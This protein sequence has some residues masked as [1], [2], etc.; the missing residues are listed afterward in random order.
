MF[1][2]AYSFLVF[3]TAVPRVFLGFLSG[4]GLVHASGT[5]GPTVFCDLLSGFPFL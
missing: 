2:T 3:S 4:L 5:G 1:A